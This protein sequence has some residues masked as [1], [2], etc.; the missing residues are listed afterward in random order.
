MS[1]SQWKK[2]LE[3]GDYFINI[4]KSSQ[5]NNPQNWCSSDFYDK[6]SSL[7]FTNYYKSNDPLRRDSHYALLHMYLLGDQKQYG[8]S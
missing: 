4:T 1:V 2:N 7:W 8:I 3:K 5:N 6:I